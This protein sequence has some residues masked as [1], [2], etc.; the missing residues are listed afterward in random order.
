MASGFPVP[1]PQTL[2]G[3]TALH[4][5]KPPGPGAT[6]L[7]MAWSHPGPEQG[8]RSAE[9]ASLYWRDSASCHPT[10]RVPAPA[11]AGAA[12]GEIWNLGMATMEGDDTSV[13]MSI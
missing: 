7:C 13:P 5:S 6:R 8:T 11:G 10:P 9:T 4:P 2:V 1:V 3:A 12:L